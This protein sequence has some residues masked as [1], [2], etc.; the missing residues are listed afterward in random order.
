MTFPPLTRTFPESGLFLCDVG[1]FGLV[2]F[3]WMQWQIIFFFII[4]LAIEFINFIEEPNLA[5]PH[6]YALFSWLRISQYFAML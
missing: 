2:S 4:S 3:G 1:S 5:E 6:H